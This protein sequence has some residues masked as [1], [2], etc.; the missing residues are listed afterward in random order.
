M[1][2]PARIWAYFEGSGLDLG[3]SS[4]D[5]G[6]LLEA[7]PGFGLIWGIWIWIW[8]YLG[9]L[10]LD[11]GLSWWAG[12]RIWAYSGRSVLDFGLVLKPESC[13]LLVTLQVNN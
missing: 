5:F 9:D 12:P 7:R 4:Q 10:G 13:D 2:G 8:A 3:T 6:L 11:V 1:G